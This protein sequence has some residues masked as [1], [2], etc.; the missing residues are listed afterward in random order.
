[1]NFKIDC[2]GGRILETNSKE[3]W[4]AIRFFL[5]ILFTLHVSRNVN[6][7]GDYFYLKLKLYKDLNWEVYAWITSFG[8]SVIGVLIII[9]IN[10]LLGGHWWAIVALSIIFGWW[11]GKNTVSQ[12]KTLKK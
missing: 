9:N 10:N 12:E 2:G 11:K 7:I 5:Y 3:L 1:M 4:A 6:K 8:I